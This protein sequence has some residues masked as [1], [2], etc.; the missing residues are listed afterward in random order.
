MPPNQ[1]IGCLQTPGASRW[2]A[3]RG[4]FFGKNSVLKIKECV[5]GVFFSAKTA[6]SKAKNAHLFE[7]DTFL[8]FPEKTDNVI[9]YDDT[10]ILYYNNTII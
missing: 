5:L 6:F 10:K 2:R 1:V 3:L 7:K 9:I 8:C 4:F